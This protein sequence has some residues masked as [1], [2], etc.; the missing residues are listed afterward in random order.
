M[1]FFENKVIWHLAFE[2]AVCSL[3]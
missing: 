1:Y 3:Y 2:E